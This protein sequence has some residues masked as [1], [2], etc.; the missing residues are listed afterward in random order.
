MSN[1]ATGA[2]STSF[3]SN[4]SLSREMKSLSS[5]CS[6]SRA[7]LSL[8]RLRDGRGNR[9][10]PT[11]HLVQRVA[12]E[13]E[14]PRLLELLAMELRRAGNSSV[15]TL[16]SR[17]AGVAS[18]SSGPIQI[19]F[20][21]AAGMTLRCQASWSWASCSGGAPGRRRRP[22]ADC[23]RRFR[24]PPPPFSTSERPAAALRPPATGR[25]R[26]HARASARRASPRA[27]RRGARATRAGGRTAG[28]SP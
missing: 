21:W 28:G 10:P 2:S 22:P 13:V 18:P 23:H 16:P 19:A 26:A 12:H 11:G 1:F 7:R 27:T 6:S 15:S 8:L 14:I 4:S 25:R 17:A 24:P 5:S 3:A 9:E 20:S